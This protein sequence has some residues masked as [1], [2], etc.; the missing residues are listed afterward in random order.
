MQANDYDGALTDLERTGQLP[1][2]GSTPWLETNRQALL[3]DQARFTLQQHLAD[4]RSG[5]PGTEAMSFNYDKHEKLMS[6][7]S[8]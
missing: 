4:L 6:L 7:R 3:Q 2:F 1:S 5:H 8:C